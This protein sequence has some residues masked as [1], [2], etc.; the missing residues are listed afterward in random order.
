MKRLLIAV[1]ILLSSCAGTQVQHQ[2]GGE[3]NVG[4]EAVWHPAGSF[5]ERVIERC[6]SP[7][8]QDLGKCFVSVMND[9]K[10]S[11][12]AT[13]FTGL[14][15]NTGY[16]RGFRE[17]GVVDVAFVEYPFRAN[18]NFGCLLVN[19]DPP[20]IDVDD[21]DIIQKIELKKDGQFSEIADA[22]PKVDIWPGDRWGADC[23]Q[24]DTLKDK[25]RF[26]TAYRLLNGCHACELLA[27]ARVA[28]D[29][30]TA[31]K[32][33]GTELLKVEAHVGIF[34]DPGK[35]VSVAI[36]R[37]FALVLESNR[38]TGYRWE[39]SGPG[40]PA[41]VKFVENEYN[42]PGTGLAGAGGKE[43][44]TFE[45]VGKGETE[46]SLKYLRPWERD[47]PPARTVSFKVNVN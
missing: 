31:G 26:I 4:P 39:T 24:P 46:I 32:F 34:N 37:K 18:E 10:A 38:T 23:I 47:L 1:V 9:Y 42:G 21:F 36:G 29:F 19:G 45:A 41:I 30:D 27:F 40:D 16:M 12:R 17:A 11:A 5:R 15:G 22:F 3:K 8:V 20:V 13:A 35:P 44:W 14:I 25:Q 43:V 7:R 2:P 33:L 28:F 6:S